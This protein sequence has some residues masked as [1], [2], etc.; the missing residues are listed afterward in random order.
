MNLNARG[1]ALVLLIALEAT[2]WGVR[3]FAKTSAPQPESTAQQED[4]SLISRGAYLAILADCTGCHTAQTPGSQPFAGGLPMASPFG[5]IYAS[6]ITPDP[7]TGIGRY[8]YEDFER[9]VR[10][11][12]APGGKHL[13]PAMPYPSFVK[14]SDED[15]RALY[16]YF[17][18]GVTP[19]SHTPPATHLPFPFNQRWGL[20]LWKAAF[21]HDKRY[22]PSA[23]HGTLWNRGAYIVQSLGH[24]GAC[25]TPRGIGFEERGLDES[26]KQFLT[27][28]INDHWFA[29]NLTGDPG[30]G[31]GRLSEQDIIAFLK[32]GHGQGVHITTFG[33]MVEVVE[34]STQHFSD[35]DLRAVARY[36]KSL[37]AQA[38]S[39]SHEPN[40]RQARQSIAALNTG[41]VQRPGAG[42]YMSLCVKCHRAD[43]QGKPDKFPAL[44]GNPAVLSADATSLIRL[45][46]QG[47]A[48]PHTLTGPASKKMPAFADKLTDTEIARVLTLI[49]S[50]WG[51]QAAPVLTRD[52]AVLRAELK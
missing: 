37:P 35:E 10:Q 38:S 46:L 20:S 25:H 7:T 2:H 28:G 24:C 52:V 16:A 17:M 40:S 39:G 15:V 26:S 4:A 11:G 45:V 13:Y 33:S 9:A 3:V 32:T 14:I 22:A 43:G 48:T 49:R 41:A 29:P 50:T 44:A 36:L 31:L 5:T 34:N 23:T 51:N 42:V 19:V 47:G 1:A 8:S 18:K 21:L 6:N 30:S 27:G 12:T